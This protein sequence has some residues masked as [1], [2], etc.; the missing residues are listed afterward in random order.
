M[1]GAS[2]PPG[3]SVPTLVELGQK[4]VGATVWAKCLLL[5]KSLIRTAQVK[6]QSSLSVKPVTVPVSVKLWKIYI[7]PQA[8]GNGDLNDTI[9][10]I[11]IFELFG[12]RMFS[13]KLLKL[14]RD[15]WIPSDS[16]GLKLIYSSLIFQF[17]LFSRMEYLGC[18]VILYANMRRRVNKA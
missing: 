13:R 2:G 11:H 1:N 4:C 9:L 14:K 18:V 17:K 7:N 15:S 3:G 5:E 8:V 6:L 12:L 16:V 10:T